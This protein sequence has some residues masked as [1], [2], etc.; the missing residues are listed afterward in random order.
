MKKSLVAL[1]TLSAMAASVHAQSSVTLYG[2]VDVGVRMTDNAGSDNEDRLT[3]V[4]GAGADTT[5]GGITP[6][7]WGIRVTED[8]GGNYRALANIEARF[9]ADSGSP[10]TTEQFQ[11][12][13]VGLVTP[14]GQVTLGRQYNVLFDVSALAFSPF[15]TMG[16]FLESYKPEI[17][18]ALGARNNNMLKYAIALGGF[19]AELQ[20]SA[21]EGSRESGAA[22]FTNGKSIG[23]MARYKFGDI[24]LGGGYLEREFSGEHKAKASL[25]GIGYDNRKLYLNAF[26]IQNDIDE[27]LALP[28]GLTARVAG[29]AI[30]YTATGLDNG[31]LTGTSPV[32]GDTG[33]ALS[34]LPFGFGSDDRKM[35]SVGGTYLVTNAFNVGLQY[36]RMEQEGITPFIPA[37]G[38]VD[39]FAAV[40]QYAFS[41]RSSIYAI[42]DHTKTS[43]DLTLVQRGA[44]A[45]STGGTA[46]PDS[47]TGIAVGIL[48]RF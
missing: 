8:L 7:R 46:G 33:T 44:G 12:S 27:D 21:G 18:M 2:V 35:F 38:E 19:V 17:G 20:V 39:Y 26:Y 36:W 6:S 24:T 40:A 30:L 43:G 10:Q 16:P 48:H 28:P 15:K 31:I 11:Q 1:A 34:S 4:N 47:R 25:V 9:L 32:P 41:K 3:S 45:S 37:E 13:W 5:A 42:V 29:P 23:G 22:T 14:F